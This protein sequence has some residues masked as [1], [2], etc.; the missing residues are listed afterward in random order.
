MVRPFSSQ[1][2]FLRPVD[3]SARLANQRERERETMPANLS[4][5]YLNAEEE[6]RRAKT[7]EERLACL[8]TMYSLMPKHKSTEKLQADI[9]TKMK[10]AK[11]EMETSRKTSKK[12][13]P[14]HHV[15]K[16]G[17]GQYVLLGAPNTGKSQLLTSLTRATP[18]V[19]PYP[20]T[21]TQPQTGMMNWEDVHLQMIE[22]PP[23]TADYMEGYVASLTRTAD[24]ALI[25]VDLSDDDGLLAVQEIIDRISK[26]K[27]F[28]VGK[29][30][31]AN[32]DSTLQFIK[33]MLVANKMDTLEAPLRLQ[34]LKELYETQFPIHAIS[35]ETGT[36]I[37]ELRNH[38]YQ[39]LNIIRVYT[40]Q[41]GKKPS[42][43]SPFTLP[44]GST[45]EELASVVHHDFA[46]KLK[47]ARIWGTAVF[48][49]QTV[50]RNH[51]LHDR[52][53]VELHI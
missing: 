16:Q 14:S 52:D 13:G 29:L 8:K 47:Y 34:L 15:P 40:K 1:I 42:L 35:A 7:P 22:L 9:K 27:T 31:E 33:S 44:N 37:E 25:I 43:K 49:G 53:V 41:P 38:I 28:L 32:D 23:I 50:K 6:F 10:R 30:P 3:P 39:F 51:V 2:L 18:E 4:R 5:Q 46:E 26:T 45:I 36:G 20:F 48:E 17:S 24:A 19:A 12:N 21:T 11:E